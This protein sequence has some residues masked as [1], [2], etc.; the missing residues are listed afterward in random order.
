MDEEL[1]QELISKKYIK[2]NTHDKF[3]YEILNYT[4][5]TQFDK[6][7]NEVTLACRG[8]IRDKTTKKIIAR[9]LPKFFNYEEVKSRIPNLPFVVYDKMDG[10]CGILYWHDDIPYIA[11]R[12]C[13]DSEQAIH[14][15]KLLHDKYK[16]LLGDNYSLLRKDLTYVFEII[17]PENRIVVS[18]DV[19]DIFLICAYEIESEKEILLSDINDLPFP[20]VKQFEGLGDLDEILK[21]QNSA[22]GFVIR[23]E[24]GFRIKIK[25]DEYKRLHKIM[26]KLSSVDIWTHL[27]NG[28]DINLILDAVPDEFY[29]E[30]R[31]EKEKL[32]NEFN[33]IELHAKLLY[34]KCKDLSK[35]E[36][37]NIL[38]SEPHSRI[39]YLMLKDG[40]YKE[41]IWECMK[42]KFRT[43]MSK[44]SNDSE[45]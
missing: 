19:D 13:F 28:S 37:S 36:I 27:K 30:V 45:N 32:E 35:K 14:A 38:A 31:A 43:I 34:D 23:F 6:K 20:K 26:T 1:V 8:L 17:Y 9:G 11:T 24:N 25:F 44:F 39:V 40:N 21:I 33:K 3:N 16:L 41:K 15:T 5:K 7:W 10:S 2:V 22:E 4:S 29:N 12:G 18:Y 42:P